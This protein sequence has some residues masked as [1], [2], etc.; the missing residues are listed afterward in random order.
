MVD[1]LV[2]LAANVKARRKALKLTQEDAAFNAS[3]STSYWS[4]IERAR[5]EPGVRMMV[6]VAAALETTPAELVT[7][8]G[9]ESSG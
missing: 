1:P 2:R 3:M 9:E 5:V 6:R 8:L 4:R 7:G